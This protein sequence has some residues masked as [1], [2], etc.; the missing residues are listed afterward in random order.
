[1]ALKRYQCSEPFQ[2]IAIDILGPLPVT[3]RG[4]KYLLV[5]TDY[6][7]KWA[8]ALP[9]VTQEAEVIAD[10]LIEHVFTRLGM[11]AELHS[12][13]G[14]NFDG[15]LIQAMCDR[16]SIN[17]TRTTPY[18]PASDGQTERQNRTLINGLAKMCDEQNS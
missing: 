15:K 2:R 4:N 6:F 7:S 17:K 5:L 8:E 3:P 16:L 11:P 12:D 18:H 14:T 13:Q 9:L 1:M 10:A